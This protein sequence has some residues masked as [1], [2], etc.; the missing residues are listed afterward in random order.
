MSSG[1]GG[2]ASGS[3]MRRRSAAIAFASVARRD[4]RSRV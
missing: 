1:S 4:F 2:S 3:S